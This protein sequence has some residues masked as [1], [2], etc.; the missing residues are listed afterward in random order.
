[1]DGNAEVAAPETL[2]ML[3]P[4]HPA[5][6]AVVERLMRNYTPAERNY[7]S[8]LGESEDEF[9]RIRGYAASVLPGL[10]C[11]AG[12]THTGDEIVTKAFKIGEAMDKSCCTKMQAIKDKHKHLLDSSDDE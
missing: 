6:S 3:R 2:V 8:A 11:L 9:D 5:A 4:A 7:W 1:M 12:L 10:A